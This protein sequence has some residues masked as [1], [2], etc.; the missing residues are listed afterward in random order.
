MLSKLGVEAVAKCDT[1]VELL[2]TATSSAAPYVKA[3]LPTYAST[4]TYG[5]KKTVAKGELFSHIPLSEAECEAG[6]SELACFESR[7]PAGCFIPS[8]KVKAEIWQ[9]AITAAVADSIDLTTPFPKDDIPAFAI[10]L[11]G[12]W[13]VEL[14]AS[15][16]RSVSSETPGGHLAVDEEKAVRFAGLALLQAKSEG[17]PVEATA[18]LRAWRDAIPEAWRSKCEFAILKGFYELQDGGSTIKYI[19]GFA[20]SLA[21]PSTATESKSLGAKRKWHEKFRASKKTA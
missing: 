5:T 19:D 16:L 1:T 21:A 8:G 17:N 10:D 18:L 2:P 11:P 15:I 13:P 9:A 20:A 7:D 14:I 12:D 6:F 4:G 3:E